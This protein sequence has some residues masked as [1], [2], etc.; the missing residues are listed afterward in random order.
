MIP[1][2]AIGTVEPLIQAVETQAN[3]DSFVVILTIF[4]TARSVTRCLLIPRRI[5]PRH[6]VIHAVSLNREY[7]YWSPDCLHR[8]P[9]N[10]NHQRECGDSR[11]DL[12]HMV[13]DL[14]NPASKVGG[15]ACLLPPSSA[16]GREDSCVKE[17]ANMLRH[18]TIRKTFLA[19]VVSLQRT[20]R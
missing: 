7:S 10:Q 2:W 11:L 5:R 6:T 9:A 19:R 3:S 13:V 8:R 4:P 16:R 20:L 15:L 14:S 18:E 17:R 12:I 1:L